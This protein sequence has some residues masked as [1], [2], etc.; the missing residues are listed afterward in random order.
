MQFPNSQLSRAKYF[1]KPAVS[2]NKIND[3]DIIKQLQIWDLWD[4]KL[5]FPQVYKDFEF[6]VLFISCDVGNPGENISG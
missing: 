6:S 1:L 3:H 5:G 4:I 2:T